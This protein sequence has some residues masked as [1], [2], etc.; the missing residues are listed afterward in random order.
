MHDNMLHVFLDRFDDLFNSR[1]TFPLPSA[2]CFAFVRHAASVLTKPE[3]RLMA[4][5]LHPN[6]MIE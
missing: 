6:N 3:F 2:A 4:V 5:Q 1:G